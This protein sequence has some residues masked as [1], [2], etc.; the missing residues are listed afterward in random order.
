[1]SPCQYCVN[2]KTPKHKIFTE[3]TV[4]LYP[5]SLT[6]VMIMHDA[7]KLNMS[8]FLPSAKETWINGSMDQWINWDITTSHYAPLNPR[9][10]PRGT[11]STSK[12]Q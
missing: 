2:G 10:K 6:Q 9:W 5:T 11:I 7:H 8:I 4:S 12:L 3:G 1:M